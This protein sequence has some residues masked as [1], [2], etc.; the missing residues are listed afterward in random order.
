MFWICARARPLCRCRR[1][2]RGCVLGADCTVR[3]PEPLTLQF[4]FSACRGVRGPGCPKCVV[5]SAALRSKLE[6]SVELRV[7]RVFSNQEESRDLKV[8][9]EGLPDLE[10]VCELL[11]GVF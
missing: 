6:A 4:S 1:R 10:V 7:S 9:V 8:A 3:L 2:R 11:C 5:Y